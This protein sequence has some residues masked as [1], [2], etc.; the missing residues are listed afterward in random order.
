MV[1]CATLVHF[2]DHTLLAATLSQKAQKKILWMGTDHY[3]RSVAQQSLTY[4]NEPAFLPG[5][6]CHWQQLHSD[7]SDFVGPQIKHSVMWYINQCLLLMYYNVLKPIPSPC[8]LLLL[9][10][11]KSIRCVLILFENSKIVIVKVWRINEC[12]WNDH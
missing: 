8:L 5:I 12:S 10:K 1:H 11:I 3:A 4:L 7:W 2:W 6:G 9:T